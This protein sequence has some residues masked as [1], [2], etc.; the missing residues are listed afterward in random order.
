MQGMKYYL[1]NDFNNNLIRFNLKMK[2]NQRIKKKKE[3]KKNNR[4]II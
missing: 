2:N 1:D 3:K 4:I